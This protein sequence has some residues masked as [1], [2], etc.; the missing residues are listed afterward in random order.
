MNNRLRRATRWPLRLGT[1]LAVAA[2]GVACCQAQDASP[3]GNAAPQPSFFQS[4]FG[5]GQKKDGRAD[6]SEAGRRLQRRSRLPAKHG[7]TGRSALRGHGPPG[8]REGATGRSP[9]AVQDGPGGLAG[10]TCGAAV[11]RAA[12]GPAERAER[13]DEALSAGDQAHPKEGAVYNS[14]AIH[15][16]Q[17]SMYRESLAAF[18]QAIVLRPKEVL[19]RNNAAA[20]LVQLNRP[21][22]AFFQLYAVHDPAMAHYNLGVLLAKNGQPQPAVRQFSLALHEPVAAAGAAMDRASGGEP[23][24]VRAVD[25]GGRAARSRPQ[26]RRREQSPPATGANSGDPGFNQGQGPGC[27]PCRRRRGRRPAEALPV[28]VGPT[29]A[30]SSSRNHCRCL[31]PRWIPGVRALPPASGSGRRLVAVERRF[32]R[33]GSATRLPRPCPIAYCPCWFRSIRCRVGPP[34]RPSLLAASPAGVILKGS[35]SRIPLAPT[36]SRRGRGTNGGLLIEPVPRHWSWERGNVS[37]IKLSH[38]ANM[39]LT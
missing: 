18:Q 9:K 17:Q 6:R 7:K 10:R 31:R 3:P 22:D 38:D 8:R 34:R 13:G 2:M 27:K 33:P 12:E 20:L 26:R 37:F 29:D 1:W 30:R 4:L 16:T 32:W 15:Y 14:L 11:V 35:S 23:A 25:G 5:G 36:L 21:Q 24:G 39:R 28:V 19:Y